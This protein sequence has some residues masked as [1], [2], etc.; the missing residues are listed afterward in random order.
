MSFS[1]INLAEI[2]N[3]TMGK[4]IGNK[5]ITESILSVYINCI[6]F[7]ARLKDNPWAASVAVKIEKDE[8]SNMALTT[9]AIVMQSIKNTTHFAKIIEFG[10]HF[11]YNF[12]VAE[13]LGPKTLLFVDNLAHYQYIHF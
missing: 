4:L 1:P 2:R 9:K 10:S 13:K 6:I 3:L 11:H 5:F 7:S 12:I 8:P